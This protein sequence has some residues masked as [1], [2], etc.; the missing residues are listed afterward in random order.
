M[1]NIN[2]KII[3]KFC[4]LLFFLTRSRNEF[5]MV[6]DEIED[7][8]LR[9]ALNGLSTETNQFADEISSQLKSLGINPVTKEDYFEDCIN[10]GE[11]LR[12]QSGRGRELQTICT[13]TEASITSA[14][15]E[16]LEDVPF[17][18]LKEMMT[19]QLNSLKFAFMKINMLNSARFAQ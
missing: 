4:G 9:T 1:E 7:C 13:E 5:E 8:G 3:D 16:I 14:Y 2:T 18:T 10:K 15:S 17:T 19:Y 6:A 12:Q 11:D